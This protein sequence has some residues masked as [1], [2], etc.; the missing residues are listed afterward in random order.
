ML[1]K[2]DIRKLKDNIDELEDLIFIVGQIVD[3]SFKDGYT[4][5]YCEG[6]HDGRNMEETK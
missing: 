6:F 2:L 4:A 5:G 1:S 3:N